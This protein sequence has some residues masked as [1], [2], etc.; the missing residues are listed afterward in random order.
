MAK[1]RKVGRYVLFFVLALAYG[2]CVRVCVEVKDYSISYF[3]NIVEVEPQVKVEKYD[4]VKW[5]QASNKYFEITYIATDQ[6]GAEILI[7]DQLSE[8]DM[9]ISLVEGLEQEYLEEI[10]IYH[11]NEDRND[12]P[13]TLELDHKETR[14]MVY[15]RK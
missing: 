13:P 1:V 3:E 7:T 9:E 12:E 14:Y 15:L 5:R 10:T 8:R 2:T 6:D 11:Y 4:I